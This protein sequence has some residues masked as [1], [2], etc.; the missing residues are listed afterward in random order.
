MMVLA[1]QADQTRIATFMFANDGSNRSYKDIGVPEGHHDC[2]HHGGDKTKQEK[3]QKINQF[4]VENLGYLLNK[5]QSI[6]EPEGT[7]LDNSMVLYGAGISDGDRHN[8]DN[9]PLVLAGKGAGT[10]KS[11]RHIVYQNE[12][13]MSNLFLCMLDR[14]G[15]STDHIGDS[16]GRLEQ[17]I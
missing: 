13:P 1:F 14:M 7:M 16:T 9:L 15:V 8:H 2:S 10:I 17:L 4:H 5:M 11:G 3:V 6:Q 12:T